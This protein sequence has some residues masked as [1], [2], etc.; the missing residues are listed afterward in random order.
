MSGLF[1]YGFHFGKADVVVGE[2]FEVGP[3]DFCGDDRIVVGDIGVGIVGAVL[4]SFVRQS[5]PG[6]QDQDTQVRS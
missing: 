4:E 6:F 3:G 1:G 5:G 2:L